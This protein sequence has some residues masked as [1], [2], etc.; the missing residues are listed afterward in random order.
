MT[1]DSRASREIRRRHAATWVAAAGVGF[2]YG[3]L[4]ATGLATYYTP[5]PAPSAPVRIAFTMSSSVSAEP[6]A[7]EVPKIL[8]QLPIEALPVSLDG[9]VQ[10]A[11]IHPLIEPQPPGDLS[12]IS[13][14][15]QSELEP[16]NPPA[17]VEDPFAGLLGREYPETPGG[18]VMVLAVLLDRFGHVHNAKIMVPSYNT[19]GDL[20]YLMSLPG[21]NLSEVPNIPPGEKRWIELRFRYETQ[22]VALP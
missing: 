21:T 20:T 17:E 7:V 5:A 13:T 14:P 15:P 22:T 6:P 8:P 11:T 9:S 4:L 3:T 12:D 1:L 10:V 19:I 16:T 2:T 18:P